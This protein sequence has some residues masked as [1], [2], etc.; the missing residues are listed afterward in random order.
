MIDPNFHEQPTPKTLGSPQSSSSQLAMMP[1]AV[2]SQDMIRAR[3][4]E[5]YESRGRES[6]QDEQDWLRAEQQI[7]KPHAETGTTSSPPPQEPPGD[8]P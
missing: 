2:P 6:G 5:L 4:Y 8:R 3:A 1:D 7:L